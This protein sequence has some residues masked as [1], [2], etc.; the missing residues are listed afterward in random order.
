MAKVLPF[1]RAS[2]SWIARKLNFRSARYQFQIALAEWLDL[3][4]RS[5][6]QMTVSDLLASPNLVCDSCCILQSSDELDGDYVVKFSG[7]KIDAALKGVCLDAARR[8]SDDTW[9]AAYAFMPAQGAR[10]KSDAAREAYVIV[11]PFVS[12]SSD[13]ECITLV[14]AEWDFGDSGSGVC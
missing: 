1:E 7:A 3:H 4:D 9:P 10:S 14:I 2:E 13:Q 8:N 6:A 12:S 11:L 5:G